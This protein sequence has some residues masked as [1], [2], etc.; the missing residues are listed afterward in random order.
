[1]E[2]Q[3]LTVLQIEGEYAVLKNAKGEELLIALALLPPGSDIGSRLVLDG[4][5]LSPA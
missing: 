5:E 4:T 2:K 1:M 3:L